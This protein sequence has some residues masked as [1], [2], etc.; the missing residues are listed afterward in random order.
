MMKTK[1]FS[2]FDMD[3]SHLEN[4]DNFYANKNLQDLVQKESKDNLLIQ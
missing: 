1:C 2:V 3:L 4:Y